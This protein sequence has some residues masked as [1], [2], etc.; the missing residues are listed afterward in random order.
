MAQGNHS[1]AL[2]KA[3]KKA[4]GGAKKRKTVNAKKHSKKKGSVAIEN[5]AG[6]VAATK[7][8]NRKNERIIAA[9]ATNSGTRFCLNDIKTKGKQESQRL[10][11]LRD[12]KQSST[13]S[14]S[15]RLKEQIKKLK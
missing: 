6:I 5:N 4:S 12:K 15:A 13:S 14:V 9:K 8:I 7:A 1:K 2:G 10:A 3:K 11:A